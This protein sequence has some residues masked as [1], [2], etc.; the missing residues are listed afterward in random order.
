MKCLHIY[1]FQ[2][3]R[4][5]LCHFPAAHINHGLW[6]RAWT[7]SAIRDTIKCRNAMHSQCLIELHR[8]KCIDSE[9]FSV[10]ILFGTKW[11][12]AFQMHLEKV[13]LACHYTVVRSLSYAKSA[14]G[15]LTLWTARLISFSFV[16]RV[17]VKSCGTLNF[18]TSRWFFF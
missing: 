16:G 1:I 2:C 6:G 14:Y 11:L 5:R 18:D 9:L 8:T 10:L 4:I 17:G 15:F 3:S 13:P 12:N 7:I